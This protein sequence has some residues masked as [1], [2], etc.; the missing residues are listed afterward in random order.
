LW[1]AGFPKPW[2]HLDQHAKRELIRRIAEWEADRK[3]S[4]PPVE[5]EE[6]AIERDLER[7]R[8][9][10][11]GEQS[12]AAQPQHPAVAQKQ[13]IPA[14]EAFIRA[15]R[16]PI[17][18]F[19]SSEP[20]LLRHWESGRKFFWSFIRIDETYGQTEACDAFKAWLAKRYAKRKEGNPH[21]DGKLMQLAAMRV[22]HYYRRSER[23]AILLSVTSK[24][25]YQGGI[26]ETGRDTGKMDVGLSRDCREA[27]K[28]FQ[29]L[30]PGQE[31]IRF[32]P[33][34]T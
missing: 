33:C 14:A 30:F 21:F 7:E 12:L 27:R 28:F 2:K 25:T 15:L 4:H 32:S 19:K 6:S 29:T 26:D 13:N 9:R 3:K 8:E 23:R 31:P 24:K 1:K 11:E 16:P 34:R 5:I 17:W 22:R 18:R 20:Q 10:M